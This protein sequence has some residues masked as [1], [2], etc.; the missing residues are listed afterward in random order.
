MAAPKLETIVITVRPSGVCLIEFN[1]PQ[2]GNAFNSTLS[3]V[4][5]PPLPNSLILGMERRTEM[6]HCEPQRQDHRANRTRKV[7]HYR[8]LPP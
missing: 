6:G 8:F 4:L 2:R 1:R 7:L 3:N 5:P